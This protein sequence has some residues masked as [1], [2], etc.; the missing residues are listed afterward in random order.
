MVSATFSLSLSL[1]ERLRSHKTGDVY[2]IT[3]VILPQLPS[4]LHKIIGFGY[5]IESARRF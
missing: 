4:V 1:C 2:K 3:L 5:L